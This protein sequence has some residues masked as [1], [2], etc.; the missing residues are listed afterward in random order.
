MRLGGPIYREDY[1]DPQGWVAALRQAGYR[2]AYCPVD[3]DASDDE[4]AAYAQAA[5]DADIVIAEV[6]A[7]SNPLSPDKSIRDAALKKCKDALRVADKIGALCA[8]NI[9]GSLG[10]KWDGPFAADLT[11]E[12]WDMIV[13]TTREIIDEVQPQ[14]AGYSLET[15]PWMYPDTVDHYL[16]LIEAIDRDKLTVHLDPVNLISSPQLYFNNTALLKEC[17]DKL[18]SRIESVHAKD[19]LLRQN[20]TV[21]LD[22]VRPGQGALDYV[23]FLREVNKLHDDAPFMLEHLP[24]KEEYVLAAEFVRSVAKQEGIQL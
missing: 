20:L 6:G 7:W 8:V 10:E 17:F 23:T 14:H 4:I 18:G 2:A 9:V 21:H 3:L 5:R 11:K 24:T 16:E 1:H 12:T 22:E 19:I 13:E 15:M